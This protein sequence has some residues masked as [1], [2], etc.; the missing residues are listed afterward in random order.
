M[1]AIIETSPRCSPLQ[2]IVSKLLLRDVLIVIEIDHPKQI[3][4]LFMLALR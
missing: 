1:N 2:Q 3:I 4:D